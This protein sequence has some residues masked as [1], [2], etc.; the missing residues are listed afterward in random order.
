MIHLILL[1]EIERM[2]PSL[3]ELVLRKNWNGKSRVMKFVFSVCRLIFSDFLKIDNP[4]RVSGATEVWQPGLS[5]FMARPKEATSEDKCSKWLHGYTFIMH[6]I[7]II[8]YHLFLLT[9]CWLVISSLT[10]ICSG[11]VGLRFA[12][13]PDSPL[14]AK[15]IP[16]Q[17]LTTM[18]CL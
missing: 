17:I 10:E 8:C 18:V 12:T 15:V 11:V 6:V 5:I 3:P 9:N 14:N 16:H 7:T 2:F 13:V 1:A 4:L